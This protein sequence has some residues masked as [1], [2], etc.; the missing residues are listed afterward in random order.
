M[1]NEEAL[2]HYI[3]FQFKI[4][5]QLEALKAQIAAAQ[6]NTMPQEINWAHVGDLNHI[7]TKLSELI[8]N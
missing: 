8:K 3:G 2:A 6:D 1:I 4:E 5:E 7:S